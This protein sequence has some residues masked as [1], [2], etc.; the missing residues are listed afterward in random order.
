MDSIDIRNCKRCEIYR[1][2]L[3][4]VLSSHIQRSLGL[5]DISLDDLRNDNAK[6]A[7]RMIKTTMPSTISDQRPQGAL[8]DG[9]PLAQKIGQRISSA[10]GPAL[11]DLS[12]VGLS[13]TRGPVQLPLNPG[14]G[15]GKSKGRDIERPGF[16]TPHMEHICA[17]YGIA[18]FA[19]DCFKLG[20]RVSLVKPTTSRF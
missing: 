11:P 16:L 14:N 20:Q 17:L 7:R 4:R 8:H 6:L 10:H 1:R 3:V 13:G 15:V 5:R 2:L 18:S 12:K 19:R 9:I